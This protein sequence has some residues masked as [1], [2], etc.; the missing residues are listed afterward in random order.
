MNH[1]QGC[2]RLEPKQVASSL[3]RQLSPPLVAVSKVLDQNI[4]TNGEY[5]DKNPLWH[6]D[7]SP[8]K[9]KQILRM[10][11]RNRLQPTT[12]CE[13]GCG[14]GEVLRLLQEKLDKA[15]CF[16]GYDISPQ[17]IKMCE[18]RA[19]Q[20][21]HFKLADISREPDA[22]FDLSLVLDVFEHVEN[23]YGFLDGIRPKSDLKIFHIPLDLSMQTVFRKRAIL[24]NH[25]QYGHLHYFTKDTALETLK[26]VGYEVLDHFYTPRAIE[27]ATTTLHKILL[28]PLRKM[29]FS[30]HRDLAVRILG[31]YGLLVLAR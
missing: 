12:I 2:S 21:L 30:I 31:G 8:F 28:S 3:Q 26:D 18:S 20:K 29:C 27:L 4:Y 15:C 24:M 14:A 17:A 11:Q 6:T 10:L 23:Y 16:W 19:N 7:E 22:F 9:V 25:D 13:V 5:L 1:Q